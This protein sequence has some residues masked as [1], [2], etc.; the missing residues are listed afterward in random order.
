[1][2][3]PHTTMPETIRDHDDTGVFTALAGHRTAAVREAIDALPL[4]HQ[5]ADASARAASAP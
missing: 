3:S 1:M 4:L 2:T 5:L